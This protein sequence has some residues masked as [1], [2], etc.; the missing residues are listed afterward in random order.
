MTAGTERRQ[1]ARIALS[2]STRLHTGSATVEGT[3]V[4]LSLGGACLRAPISPPLAVGDAL[5]VEIDL[6]G[7]DEPLR[8]EAVV[9][10]VDAIDAARVGVQF[11][12]GLR[13]REAY[14]V[15]RLV[16]ERK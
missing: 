5:T 3:L 11:S 4:D 7:L 12:T 8:A 14:A 10:W 16:R 13:A 15:G 6:P 1:H 9:R 2:C